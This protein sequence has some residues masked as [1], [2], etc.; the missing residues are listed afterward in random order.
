MGKLK[1]IKKITIGR[2]KKSLFQVLRDNNIIADSKNNGK[3]IDLQSSCSIN[4]M[5]MI[6]KLHEFSDYSVKKKRIRTFYFLNYAQEKPQ[7]KKDSEGRLLVNKYSASQKLKLASYL[8]EVSRN[9]KKAALEIQAAARKE[10]NQNETFYYIE[11]VNQFYKK[12]EKGKELSIFG[13]I[14]Q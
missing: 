3:M 13:N 5:K 8:L 6:E 4:V 9:A 7:K 11:T 14:I 2:K 12:E 10:D 1:T